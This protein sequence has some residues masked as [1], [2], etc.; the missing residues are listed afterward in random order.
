M[1][2]SRL[3]RAREALSFDD[4]K[5]QFED[6][7]IRDIFADFMWRYLRSLA[8]VPEFKPSASDTFGEIYALASDELRDDVLERLIDRCRINVDGMSFRG[9]NVASLRTPIDVYKFLSTLADQGAEGQPVDA[10]TRR[11]R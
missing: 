8:F 9:L 1:A 4:F 3:R 5:A 2:Q 7:P 6:S 10:G 11:I